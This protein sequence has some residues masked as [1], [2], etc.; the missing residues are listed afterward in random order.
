MKLATEN[1]AMYTD[2]TVSSIATALATLNTTDNT[3]A[4]LEKDN[5][6]LIQVANNGKKGFYVE[7]QDTTTKNTIQCDKNIT[8]VKDVISLFFEFARNEE[9]RVPPNWT[10]TNR[11]VIKHSKISQKLNYVGLAF[12][13]VSLYFIFTR[14][15]EDNPYAKYILLIGMWLMVP[16][17]LNSSINFIRLLRRKIID[18]DGMRSLAFLIIVV[19][20]TA[21]MILSFK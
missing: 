3:F 19:I 12:I 6:S 15:F 17:A 5:G 4:I 2:V 11:P 9:V 18:A 20:V 16:N 13:A 7:I 21:V 1:G 8:E 14:R 10:K